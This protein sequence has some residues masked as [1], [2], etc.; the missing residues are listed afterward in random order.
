MRLDMYKSTG[1][2]HRRPILWC[3]PSSS[4]SAKIRSYLVKA[5]IDHEE[6]FPSDERFSESRPSVDPS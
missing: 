4:W 6:R 1:K 5:G 3:T 2:Q